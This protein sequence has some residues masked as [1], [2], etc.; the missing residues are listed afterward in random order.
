ME[1][2]PSVWEGAA[3]IR[4]LSRAQTSAAPGKEA[5]AVAIAVNA[6]RAHKLTV[7]AKFCPV[8]LSLMTL[9]GAKRLASRARRESVAEE[10]SRGICSMRLLSLVAIIALAA[11]SPEATPPA[12]EAASG[13]VMAVI[14][15]SAGNIALELYPDL[16]PVTVANFVAHAQAGHLDGG[17]FY[18]SVRDDND[19]ADMAPMNLIQGGHSFGGLE[20]AQGITHESTEATGLSHVRGAISMARLEPG[21]ATTEFFIMVNDYDGLDAGP[22]RRNPDEAGYAVFGRVTDGMEVVEAIWLGETS[23]ERAPEDFQFAQFLVEPVRIDRVR[24]LEE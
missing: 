2:A 22:G 17:E 5:I 20:G 16:A 13:P 11:C 7:R 23:L 15:T 8:N 3:K 12:D 19:R 9:A 4:V 10:I 6:A 21:T 18:R 1:A 14:E 24:I